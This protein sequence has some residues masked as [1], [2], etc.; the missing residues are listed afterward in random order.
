MP[1]DVPPLS[2]DEIREI[3]EVL[4]RWGEAHPRRHHPLIRLGDGS[5]IT[6][7]DLA[8]AARE[9]RS[10]VGALLYRVFAFGTVDDEF[11]RGRTVHELLKPYW[12]DLD[13]WLGV[14]LQ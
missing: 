7:A 12:L 8:R 13:E 5:E 2:E 1:Q 3:A 6:P 9:P 11:E 14:P 4:G 10:P